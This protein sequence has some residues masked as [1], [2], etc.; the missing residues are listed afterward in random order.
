MG[1]C[2]K[3]WKSI[4]YGLLILVLNGVQSF[5]PA[6]L[7]HPAHGCVVWHSYAVVLPIVIMIKMID[8]STDE[9]QLS[10]KRIGLGT[11]AIKLSQAPTQQTHTL[12]D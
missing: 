12:I 8:K 2:A 10:I 9:T 7:L 4:N 3:Q 1:S 11:M 5:C 6:D